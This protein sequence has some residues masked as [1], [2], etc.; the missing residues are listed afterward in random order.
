M[1]QSNVT[2]I[3]ANKATVSSYENVD[4]SS[5]DNVNDLKASYADDNDENNIDIVVESVDVEN[6]NKDTEQSGNKG[7]VTQVET[8][9][10]SKKR[11][12]IFETHPLLTPCNCKMKCVD[13]VSEIRRNEIHAAFWKMETRDE[14]IA[15]IHGRIQV[16]E[17]NSHK[18]YKAAASIV[19]KNRKVSRIYRFFVT[20]KDEKLC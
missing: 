16:T 14:R 6:D 3:K 8:P 5:V 15:W 10:S 2:V 1:S 12:S 17:V 11:K 7:N 20:S 4:L 13:R 18:V 19:E 9:K